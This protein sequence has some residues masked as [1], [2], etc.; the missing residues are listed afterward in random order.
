MGPLKII[1]SLKVEKLHTI[2]KGWALWFTLPG[3]VDITNG[4]I[5]VQGSTKQ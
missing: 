4:R 3:T 5:T 2:K 1:V